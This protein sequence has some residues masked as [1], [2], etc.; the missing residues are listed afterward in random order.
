[1]PMNFIPKSQKSLLEGRPIVWKALLVGIILACLNQYTGCYTLTVYSVVIFQ[2]SG[3]HIDPHVS[4]IIL[5]A[6]Q[7]IGIL[8]STS[9]V[10]I[11]GRKLLLTISIAGSA[12]GLSAMSTYMYLDSIG[13]DLSIVHWIPV[14]SIGFVVLISSLGIVPLIFVCIVEMLP[15]EVSRAS[16]IFEFMHTYLIL[17]KFYSSHCFQKG[18]WLRYHSERCVRQ[19][20]CV[21]F[22]ENISHFDPIAA[23]ARQ[24]RNLCHHM[25]SR[26]DFCSWRY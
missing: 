18:P 20:V 24:Y 13:F 16:T 23:I 21:H 22:I 12:L 17:Q 6:L 9:L 11:I 3:T 7:V 10:E 5:G 1:M 15:A 19:H 4:S 8:G 14:V 2:Q 26:N 25:C